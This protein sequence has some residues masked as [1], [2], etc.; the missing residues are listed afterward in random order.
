MVASLKNWWNDQI[1]KHIEI[2]IRLFFPVLKYK[3][4]NGFSNF[5]KQLRMLLHGLKK[6]YLIE[7]HYWKEEEEFK[8]FVSTF[9]LI[10]NVEYR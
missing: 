4:K 10:E 1:L 8:K 3:E 5:L 9:H 2:Y 6:I 7:G